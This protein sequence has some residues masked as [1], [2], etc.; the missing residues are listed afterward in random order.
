[1]AMIN[2]DDKLYEKVEKLQASDEV[3]F[4]SIKNTVERMILFCLKNDK[5]K[6]SITEEDSSHQ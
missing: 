5:F 3:L 6:K 1:M 4:P 2:V